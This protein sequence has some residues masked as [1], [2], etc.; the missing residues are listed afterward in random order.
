[1]MMKNRVSILW[2]AFVLSVSILSFM[3]NAVAQDNKTLTF[4]VTP[5]IDAMSIER[6]ATPF[7]HEVHQDIGRP[8]QVKVSQ[9]YSENLSWLVNGS[10][11]TAFVGPAHLNK[12]KKHFN[13]VLEFEGSQEANIWV[14]DDSAVQLNL[15]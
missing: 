15:K 3:R 1:M 6:I 4:A 7:L 12:I 9:S 11:D 10:I 5:F 14:R 13:I 2:Y 8:I